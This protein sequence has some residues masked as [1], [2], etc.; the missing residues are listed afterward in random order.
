MYYSH[1]S[2]HSQVDQLQQNGYDV[3]VLVHKP[4]EPGKS[5]HLYR[6]YSTPGC[7]EKYLESPLIYSSWKD[8]C[9]KNSTHTPAT[10]QSTTA[11]ESQPQATPHTRTRTR[12]SR[13]VPTTSGGAQSRS[14]DIKHSS[15]DMLHVHN[16]RGIAQRHDSSHPTHDTSQDTQSNTQRTSQ[17]THNT[18]H[19]TQSLL[20]HD[21][22]RTSH[23]I[24]QGISQ[25]L[26][27]DS[28][29][30]QPTLNV[31]SSS[32]YYVNSLTQGT[33]NP[34]ST[35]FPIPRASFSMPYPTT[36]HPPYQPMFSPFQSPS[37]RPLLTQSRQLPS[38]SQYN[39]NNVGLDTQEQ[40]WTPYREQNSD[41]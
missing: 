18:S 16:D 41:Q 40:M 27:H 26:A 36:Y 6:K 5:R 12:R 15:H 10:S 11:S 38:L 33:P 25:T 30:T 7:A 2:I 37:P 23:H 29:S 28:T 31:Q 21:V 35:T 34:V 17:D 39:Y 20:S 4:N 19:D 3:V 1:T 24:I 14:H 13:N 32:Y 9:N 22:Q 8:H